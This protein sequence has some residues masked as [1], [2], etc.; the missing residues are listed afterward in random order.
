MI[1]HVYAVYEV[2]YST[3]DSVDSCCKEAYYP[4]DYSN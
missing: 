1:Y 4:H 3:Y 2:Y